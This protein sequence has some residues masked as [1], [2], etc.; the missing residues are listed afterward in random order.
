M[1]VM[2]EI[3]KS[4]QQV[5][6]RELRENLADVLNDAAVRGKITY[7]TNRGRRFAAVVPVEV[8]EEA[9]EKHR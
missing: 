2:T 6:T 7:V 9:E 1:S 3:E 5:S 4:A 8:A